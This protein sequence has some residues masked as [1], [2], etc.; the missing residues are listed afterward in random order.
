MKVARLASNLITVIAFVFAITALAS[1]EDTELIK[2]KLVSVDKAKKTIVIQ[3]EKG[4][5][6]TIFFE[7][8]AVFSRIERFKIE[9]GEKISIRYIIKN[10]KK[11]GTYIRSLRGC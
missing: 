8:D 2:G 10:G 3:D 6:T 5:K 7:D 11:I 9:I 4:V 1:S